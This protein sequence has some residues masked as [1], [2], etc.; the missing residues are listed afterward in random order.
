MDGDLGLGDGGELFLKVLVPH[1]KDGGECHWYDFVADHEYPACERTKGLIE[2]VC[3][4]Q[5]KKMEVLHVAHVGSVAKRQLRICLDFKII[6][7]NAA[8]E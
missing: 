2:R 7:S 6:P 4:E 5:G 3:N 1:L 8:G